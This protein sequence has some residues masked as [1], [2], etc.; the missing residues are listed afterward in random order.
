MNR[1]LSTDHE[2]LTLE[3]KKWAEGFRFLAGVDEVG[4]GPLAG[5]VVATAVI[6]PPDAKIP[7][8]NDSKKLNEKQRLEINRQILE[9]NDIRYAIGEVSVEEIDKLNIL[10]AAH[11]AMQEAVEQLPETEFALIDGLPLP[12]FPVPF[13]AV[14]KGDSKSASI[15]A[16]SII[17]KVYRDELMD[18]YA[19]EYP[20]YGFEKHKGY[21]TKLHLQALKEHGPSPIH[22]KSFAPVRDIIDPPPIQGTFDFS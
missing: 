16:A 13:E 19:D 22:R 5:P 3:H 18:K 4:R 17:A 15:A 11:L 10:K 21:G 14:V 1:Y 9:V 20:N 7:S 8:V 12:D 2:L 6:F